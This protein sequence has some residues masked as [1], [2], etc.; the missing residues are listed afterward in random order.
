MNIST[1]K[2]M[3]IK[4]NLNSFL[5]SFKVTKVSTYISKQKETN[6]R[7][8]IFKVNMCSGIDSHCH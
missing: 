6:I 7:F 5:N 8:E 2:R 1:H 3:F 4:S